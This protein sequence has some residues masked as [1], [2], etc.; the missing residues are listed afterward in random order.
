MVSFL[1]WLSLVIIGV[2]GLNV[3]RAQTIPSQPAQGTLDKELLATW[4]EG[5]FCFCA[6]R[7]E[8]FIAPQRFVTGLYGSPGLEKETP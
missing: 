5:A 3:R 8:E 7:M 6:A 4:G 1:S 2:C